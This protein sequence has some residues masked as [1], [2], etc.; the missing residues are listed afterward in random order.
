MK[1]YATVTSE[2]ASK[3]Q[4]G[5]YLDIDIRDSKRNLIFQIKVSENKGDY[6]LRYAVGDLYEGDPLSDMWWILK[7]KLSGDYCTKCEKLWEEHLSLGGHCPT[8]QKGKKQKGDKQCSGILDSGRF[9]GRHA[10][11][12]DFCKMHAEEIPT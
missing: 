3:G 4:G 8:E 1:L 5:K 10:V 9:C 11:L 12:G 6:L 7:S 2:R